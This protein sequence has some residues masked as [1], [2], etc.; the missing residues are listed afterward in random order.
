MASTQV[1]RAAAQLHE[2]ALDVAR[3][4]ALRSAQ[5]EQLTADPQVP[6]QLGLTEDQGD[7]LLVD[8]S[9]ADP[10]KDRAQDDVGRG[11]APVRARA[12]AGDMAKQLAAR[13]EGHGYRVMFPPGRDPAV[14]TVTGLPGSP[15]VEVTAEDDGQAACYYTGRTTAEAAKV[16]ARLPVP[17]K[18][19]PDTVT[20]IWDGIEIEW[21]YQPPTGAASSNQVAAAMLIHLAVLGGHPDRKED[22]T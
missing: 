21:H 16:I 13:L 12:V 20:A 4:A 22:P 7:T 1:A 10:K 6:Q 9:T 15:Y 3:V 17:G 18:P 5:P 19:P 2:A 8:A 14:F 11:G